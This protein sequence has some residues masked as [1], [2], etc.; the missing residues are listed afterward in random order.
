ML[1]S[2]LALVACNDQL[3]VARVHESDSRHH[4]TGVESGSRLSRHSNFGLSTVQ[5]RKSKKIDT[6]ISIISHKSATM[7][8]DSRKTFIVRAL[9]FKEIHI[10]VYTL[11]FAFSTITLNFKL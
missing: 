11:M 1:I 6:E 3:D 5:L 8:G 4:Q 2:S 9:T 7:Y 10:L